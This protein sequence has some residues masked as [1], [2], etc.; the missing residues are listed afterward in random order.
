[1]LSTGT[2]NILQTSRRAIALLFRAE[3]KLV[4][5]DL[6]DKYLNIIQIKRIMDKVLEISRQLPPSVRIM[7]ILNTMNKR[8]ST[9]K[10]AH[11]IK[12]LYKRVILELINYKTKKSY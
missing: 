11:T 2:I 4:F 9:I 12:D 6:Q 5:K 3:I 1:M 7:K 8:F 10:K